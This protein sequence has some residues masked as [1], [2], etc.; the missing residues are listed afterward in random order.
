MTQVGF[1]SSLFY[2]PA[3]GRISAESLT[4]DANGIVNDK[5]YNKNLDRSVLIATLDSYKLVAA[6]GI[7]VT[8]GALGENLL[9][10]YNP[11]HLPAGTRVKIGSVL[12]EISQ[13]CTLCK[14]LSQVDARIP[15]L[16]KHD[17][18]IFAKVIEPGSIAEGDSVYLPD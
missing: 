12:L 16:L 1:I 9:M 8:Y 2:S 14:S 4:L 11:Y 10:D 7:N 5:H 15:K 18:G 6:Q 3:E 13:H 17:R